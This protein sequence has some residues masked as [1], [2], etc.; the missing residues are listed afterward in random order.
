[1]TQSFPA[2]E[3]KASALVS[4]GFPREHL[5]ALFKRHPRLVTSSREVV[6]G[7]L[8]LVED[9]TGLA[10][11]S[12]A[13]VQFIL[14]AHS[15]LFTNSLATHQEGLAYLGSLGVTESGKMQALKI[16][17]TGFSAATLHNR[18][19]YLTSKFGWSQKDV[20]SRVSAKP[21]IL[22]L[23]SSRIEANL[24]TLQ[25]L[26][27]SADAVTSMSSKCSSLLTA[28]WTTQ[29]RKDKWH[30][31]ANVMLVEHS[32]LADHPHLL[33]ASLAK[34]VPRWDFLCLLT[35]KGN[36]L[37]NVQP[38]SL[39]LLHDQKSDAK[40]ASAFGASAVHD[41]LVYDECF[42]TASWNTYY[43]VHVKQPHS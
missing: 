20:R 12:S 38:A 6:V 27:S 39:V 25:S 15:R 34:L 13:G 4:A 35:L 11:T 16:G 37:N 5:G 29:L 8:K 41:D 9:V 26:G 42:R 43:A 32:A 36:M 40:F 21:N 18:C 28:N 17:V 24:H 30:F 23:T 22:S 1:M 2:L 7:I 10:L 33:E 3:A 14:R 31:I 19:T